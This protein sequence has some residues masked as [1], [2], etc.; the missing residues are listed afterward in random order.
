[1]NSEIANLIGSGEYKSAVLE[2]VNI[3][4]HDAKCWEHI[5]VR[6]DC[7]EYIEAFALDRVTALKN[8]IKSIFEELRK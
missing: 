1:M 7:S 6:D 2:L 5:M 4:Q 8:E 3:L